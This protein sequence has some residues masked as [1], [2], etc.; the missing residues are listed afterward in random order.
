M[1]VESPRP[2]LASVLMCLCA[3]LV[4]STSAAGE[5]AP[6]VKGERVRFS[7]IF[8]GD[9]V[10]ADVALGAPLGEVRE[11]LTRAGL[12]AADK[13]KGCLYRTP[14]RATIELVTPKAT[15]CNAARTGPDRP[16]SPIIGIGYRGVADKDFDTST[17][18]AALNRR[19]GADGVCAR[20]TA[21]NAQCSW[22]TPARF[23]SVRVISLKISHRSI[24]VAMHGEAPA[25]SPD[26]A[27]QGAPE[28][29]PG[30]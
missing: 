13:S 8:D 10:P 3:V 9:A 6:P 18:I 19:I 15:R 16:D 5:P 20:I 4:M 24:E 26:P 29:G 21:T 14:S 25:A 11:T 7:A 12:T 28:G 30:R 23:P 22:R 1:A 27:Q 17:E 2:R